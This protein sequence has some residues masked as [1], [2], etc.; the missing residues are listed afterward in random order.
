MESVQSKTFR[1]YIKLNDIKY[2]DYKKTSDHTH[3]Q[4]VC[5]PRTIVSNGDVI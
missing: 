1:D 2:F 3:R 4:K 5:L